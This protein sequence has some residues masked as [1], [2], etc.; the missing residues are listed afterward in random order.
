MSPMVRVERPWNRKSILS[1]KLVDN[2]KDDKDKKNVTKSKRHR[3]FN[4]KVHIRVIFAKITILVELITD[5][6]SIKKG[7]YKSKRSSNKKA[8][9]KIDELISPEEFK[10]AIRLSP[11]GKATGSSMLANKILKKLSEVANAN[12]LKIYNTVLRL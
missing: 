1:K 5:E 9:S 4:S 7:M 2:G 12:L 11:I 6:Q 8:F 10:E 3:K